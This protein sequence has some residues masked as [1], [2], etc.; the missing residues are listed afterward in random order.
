M[1]QSFHR[2][3]KIEI[4]SDLVIPLLNIY[5]KNLKSKSEN[6]VWMPMLVAALFTKAKI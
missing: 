1:V 3:L 4:P 5:P 6:D 2:K